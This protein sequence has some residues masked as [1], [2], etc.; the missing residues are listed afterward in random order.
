MDAE[1][2]GLTA[3]AGSQFAIWPRQ[4]VATFARDLFDARPFSGDL[5]DWG[6]DHTAGFLPGWTPRF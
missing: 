5:A 2:G 4:N 1:R 3:P 6:I